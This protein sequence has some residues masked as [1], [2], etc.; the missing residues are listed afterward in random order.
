MN[1]NYCRHC[2]ANLEHQLG[3]N[4][5]ETVYRCGKCGA[6]NYAHRHGSAENIQKA[7]ESTRKA[8]ARQ[9]KG[10][11]IRECK[12]SIAE[13]DEKMSA[14]AARGI[15]V[16]YLSK[17][18][19]LARD[20]LDAL[21]RAYSNDPNDSQD[22][23]D[24]ELYAIGIEL[25]SV[26]KKLDERELQRQREEKKALKEAAKAE[27]QANKDRKRGQKQGRGGGR[28]ASRNASSS[29]SRGT[30]TSASRGDNHSTGWGTAR[31]TSRSADRSANRSVGRSA[32]QSGKARAQRTHG[33]GN[34]LL[35]SK[36][37]AFAAL[38]VVALLAAAYYD[39]PQGFMSVISKT[40][41]MLGDPFRI[42]L[43]ILS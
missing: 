27:K 17:R 8:A 2:G 38:A 7:K 15:N 24:Y 12:A 5:D 36:K 37:I 18:L 19:D 41:E 32:K 23:Y 16:H 34:A 42:I 3:A 22:K 9:E 14:T 39:D 33:A 4:H 1:T 13:M 28:S 6:L 40:D 20:R 21:E 11:K 26:D 31:S 10:A 25:T 35:N 30:G 43:G 29:T